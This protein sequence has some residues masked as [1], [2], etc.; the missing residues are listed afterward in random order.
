MHLF[1]GVIMALR[2]PRAHSLADD[3]PQH[4]FESIALLSILAKRVEE[5]R[6]TA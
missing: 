1:E 2:N 5:A 4:A 3:S 6:R